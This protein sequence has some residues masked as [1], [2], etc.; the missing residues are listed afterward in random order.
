MTQLIPGTL[1]RST[2]PESTPKDPGHR[3]A[4]ADLVEAF[5]ALHQGRYTPKE[6]ERWL[7]ERMAPAIN[8]ARKV[9]R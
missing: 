3:Q 7:A 6:V 1:I 4:L 8:A 5:D 9:L 2:K